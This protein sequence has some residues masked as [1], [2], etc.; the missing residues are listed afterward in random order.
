MQYIKSAGFDHIRL[1]VDEEQLWDS[2]GKRND[3]AFQLLDNF[4]FNSGHDGMLPYFPV[5]KV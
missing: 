4:G 5:C 3:D 2:S 1:P